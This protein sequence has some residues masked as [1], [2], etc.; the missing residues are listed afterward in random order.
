MRD[1]EGRCS[2]TKPTKRPDRSW[3][4]WGAAYLV[5]LYLIWFFINAAILALFASE[6]GA[7][8]PTWR[9]PDVPAGAEVVSVSERCGNGPCWREI[10]IRP[11]DGQ[12]A[13]DL[14]AE[15]GLSDGS[16]TYGWRP[17]NPASVSVSLPYGHRGQQ[18]LKV[19]V[20]Y[21]SLFPY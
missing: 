11:A 10:R 3:I 16:R 9:D 5:T 8:P 6:G 2:S 18:Y 4:G 15:M 14:A 1:S 17:T 20:Q 21:K 13:T 12:D 19:V 7:V